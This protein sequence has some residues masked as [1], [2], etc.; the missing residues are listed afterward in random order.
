MP[1]EPINFDRRFLSRLFPGLRLVGAIR[2]A[3]DLRKLVIAALGLAL[4]QLGWAVLDGLFP[5]SAA[6]TPSISFSV[7]QIC[8]DSG[9]QSWASAGLR[10][11]HERLAEPFWNLVSPLMALFDPQSDWA[12]LLHA[13]LAMT[14]LL[15]IWA[16]CGCAICRIAV[17]RVARLQQTGLGEALGFALR[18]LVPLILTHMI[19]LGCLAFFATILAGFGAL[20]RLPWFGSAFAGV[21]FLIPLCLG[22]IMTLL[23]IAL[24]AG[25]PLGHAAIAAGA[26][27]ALDALSR[28]FGYLNQRIG[29]LVALVGFAWVEGIIGVILMDLLA[30][31]VLRLTEW[32]LGL[33]GPAT[34]MAAIFGRAGSPSSP[35]SAAGHS[36]WLNVVNTVAHSWPYSF[37][38]TAAALIYLWLRYDVDGTPWEEIDPPG[39]PSAS[40]IRPSLSPAAAAPEPP[41][42]SPALSE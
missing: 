12:S 9:D 40:Q 38:W 14:W 35:V 25:W 26:E 30:A 11:A 20:Y 18:N 36:F 2:M 7:G 37:F 16:I 1:G 39:D 41:S 34:E 42:S 10:R 3:F 19:P 27:D 33:T 17:V 5:A 31:S 24:A 4:L 15:L 22:L 6:M 8:I 32:G 28:S 13:V 23:A 21:L 29:S